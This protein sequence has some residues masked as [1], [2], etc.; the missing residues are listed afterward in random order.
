VL[1]SVL[2]HAGLVLAILY[3]RRSSPPA[4]AHAMR[5]LVSPPGQSSV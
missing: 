5:F 1:T 3:F 4:E 2:L